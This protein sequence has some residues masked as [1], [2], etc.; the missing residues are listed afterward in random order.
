MTFYKT[1]RQRGFSRTN[2]KGMVRVP[3]PRFVKPMTVGKVK[4]IINAELKVRDLGVGP[5]DLPSITGLVLHISNIAQGDL[6]TERNGNWIKPTTWMGTI[7]VRGDNAANPSITP[8]YR[9]GVLCWKENDDVNTPT[10]AKI[11]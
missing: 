7:T 2:R 8:Q 4:R 5:V 3:R 11:M 6:N 1:R 10:I 9:V